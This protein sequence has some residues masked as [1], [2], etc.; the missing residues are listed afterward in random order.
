MD[1]WDYQEYY[2]DN[3]TGGE[4]EDQKMSHF[5][6]RWTGGANNRAKKSRT[7]ANGSHSIE[8]TLNIRGENSSLF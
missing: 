5:N 4:S 8:R 3:D 6:S 2:D 7:S 1:S